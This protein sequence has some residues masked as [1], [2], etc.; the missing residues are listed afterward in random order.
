LT[1]ELLGDYQHIIEDI[2]LIT[3]SGGAFEI[4]VND[5]LIFSKKNVQK[6]HADPG[7]IMAL[8]REIVG[9]DTPTYPQSDS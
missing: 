9:T 1:D 2:V 7:E 8:F 4:K 3:S 5:E 6:R